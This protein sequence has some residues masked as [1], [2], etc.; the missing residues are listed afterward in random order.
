[1]THPAG[2][3]Q[4]VG[5]AVGGDDEELLRGLNPAQREAVVAPD[6]PVLVLAGAGSGKTRVLT[7]R[8]AYLLAQRRAAADRVMAVT[9]TNKAAREMRHRITGL[10]GAEPHGMWLGTFHACSARILRD[11]G[12][13]IGIPRNFVIYDEVDRTAL[14]KEAIR[15]AGLDEKRL[16]PATAGG[17]ISR[18]KNELKDARAFADSAVGYTESQVAL[19]YPRYQTLLEAAGA[20]DFDDLLFRVVELL[21]QSEEARTRY[22]HRFDHVLVDEYQDTNRAQYLL[23]RDLVEEHRRITVVGDPDQSVYSWRGADIRN[24]LEFQ[25]DYPDA[26]V[27]PLEQNYRSTKAILAAAQSVI[28]ENSER[29]EKDLWTEGAD[30]TAVVVAQL[31]DE[32]EEAAAV[33]REA[34][35]LVDEGDCDFGDMAILYRTNAQSRA[36]EETLLRAGMPYRLVGGVR[37]YQRREVKDVLA[38]LR[39]LAHP[40]DRLAF[41]RVVNVPK[42]GVG[43]QSLSELMRAAGERRVSHWELLVDPQTAGVRGAAANGLRRFR[44][45]IEEVAEWGAPWPLV[46]VLDKLLDRSGYRQFVRDGSI[47]GEE[48]WANVVE[49]RGLAAEQGDL[50]SVE[51]L[52]VFLEQVALAGEVDQMDDS[53]SAL[54]LITLH[55][56]KGLEFPVVFITGVE[57]GLLPHSRSL[58]TLREIEE[59]RRLLYVGM[60]RAKRRLYLSHCFRRHVYG[61]PAP[62]IPSRF[63]AA[64][65]DRAEVERW[66]AGPSATRGYEDRPLGGSREFVAPVA[67]RGQPLPLRRARDAVFEHA[68]APGPRPPVVSRFQAGDRVEHARFGRGVIRA[69]EMTGAGE[70]VVIDFESAGHRRFAVSDAV[71]RRVEG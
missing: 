26:L 39:L 22:R 42:R 21:Q 32:R 40:R 48:R 31:Y 1:M 62:A 68:T 23:L 41:E 17:E 10:L 38:Y 56:V 55:Q 29:V 46:T 70:E 64:L 14:V 5:S 36:L 35:R 15:Q 11:K 4:S 45:T 51:A 30:G 59:E 67:A 60:T 53:N 12:E 27:I 69:S 33:A 8:I 20:L 16:S 47:E 28:R 63:L 9:F 57:E 49:L 6:R 66:D 25:R 50:P 71:L 61:S 52:P 43:A 19:V 24:I 2:L 13:L 34:L 3:G 7:H 37:F 58:D 18:A 44:E 54:T 65:G